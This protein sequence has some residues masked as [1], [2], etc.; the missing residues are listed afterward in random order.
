M[1]TTLQ[2]Q[3][4]TTGGTANLLPGSLAV[5]AALNTFAVSGGDDAKRSLFGTGAMITVTQADIDAARAQRKAHPF[6]GVA[7]ASALSV[8]ILREFPHLE[9]A[10]T[11]M[12]RVAVYDA[13]GTLQEFRVGA[14]VGAMALAEDTGAPVTPCVVV[15][16]G[17]IR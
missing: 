11:Y 6:G 16:G 13:A 1:S 8:A 15:I 12:D 7:E 10:A 17:E 3:N 5:T 9:S 2:N 4:T 14:V